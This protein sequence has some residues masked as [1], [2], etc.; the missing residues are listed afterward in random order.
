M[1]TL[2]LNVLLAFTVHTVLIT[3]LKFSNQVKLQGQG[4]RQGKKNGWDPNFPNLEENFSDN[5]RENF[6]EI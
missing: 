4:H 5:F 1:K 3:R 6:K 2:A